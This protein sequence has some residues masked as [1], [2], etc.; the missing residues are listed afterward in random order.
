MSV[1]ENASHGTD[2]GDKSP[3]QIQR[4]VQSSR[5]RLGATLDQ[6]QE[7]LTPGQM[8]DEVL[9]YG[10]K[11]G[12]GEFGTNFVDQVKANPLP[13]ALMG[14]ALGWMML[15][16][17]SGQSEVTSHGSRGAGV[18]AEPYR[19]RYANGATTGPVGEDDGP[20]LLDRASDAASGAY[21][22]ARDA[23][24][25]AYDQARDGVSSTVEQMREGAGAAMD[26]ARDAASRTGE[27]LG[28]F[29]RS[30]R[31]NAGWAADQTRYRA[32]QARD[33]MGAML[34][35]HPLVLGGLGLALGA[36]F[37]ALLP[38]TEGEDRL[39]GAASDRM[40][41]QLGDVAGEAGGQAMEAAQRVAGA[42]LA[43]GETVVDEK[44]GEV[45]AK[46]DDMAETVRPGS[47]REATPIV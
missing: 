46:T 34:T 17:R 38:G 8:L 4:E 25:T 36:A 39:M 20:G 43:E 12:A 6:I 11:S 30:A 22:Q 35:E 21:D 9:S 33:R 7:R 47:G 5:A 14:A 44:I 18:R 19:T 2:P 15:A 45:E 23:A 41:D 26:S 37:A 32:G 31:D 40:K 29:S 24:S 27:R 10:R 28:D 3:E 16:P 13:V 1:F 42:A